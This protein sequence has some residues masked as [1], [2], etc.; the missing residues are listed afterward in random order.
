MP[1]RLPLALYVGPAHILAAV[2]ETWRT[3]FVGDPP[4][5]MPA[6][7]AFMGSMWP[8]FCDTLD[9]AYRTGREQRFPC[10]DHDSTVVILP[11]REA[12]RVVALVTGCQL[13]RIAPM[14]GSP[15][16]PAPSPALTAPLPAEPR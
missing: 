9:T 16:L 11:L 15:R 14:L 6:R 5:G 7:E 13:E 10:P 3:V 12:G 8:Q 2:N 1:D 4:L